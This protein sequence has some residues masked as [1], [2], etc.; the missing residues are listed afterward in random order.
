MPSQG[1][2][3][4]SDSGNAENWVR[5]C[6]KKIPLTTSIRKLSRQVRGAIQGYFRIIA[7]VDHPPRDFIYSRQVP[8]DVWRI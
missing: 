5:V 2:E 4:L 1:I 7:V 3:G 8:S 6:P